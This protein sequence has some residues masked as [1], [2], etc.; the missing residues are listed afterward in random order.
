MDTD[1][2]IS[3]VE[4]D[5]MLAA[6]EAPYGEVRSACLTVLGRMVEAVVTNDRCFH[7]H[8]T[9]YDED[10]AWGG[11]H[12]DAIE[13]NVDWYSG[14]PAHV[15]C[16]LIEGCRGIAL[17]RDDGQHFRRVGDFVRLSVS[18]LND[19]DTFV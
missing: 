12:P 13:K 5:V 19:D 11:F 2:K 18:D 17:F 6:P 14:E 1:W 3:I 4:C 10:Q 7:P 15:W 16:L 8:Q 9:V